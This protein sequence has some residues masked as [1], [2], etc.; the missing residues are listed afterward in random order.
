[1]K[2][3]IW[4]TVENVEDFREFF[5][6]ISLEIEGRISAKFSPNAR[7]MF[8]PS[9]AKFSPELRSGGLRGITLSAPKSRSQIAAFS[10]RRFSFASLPT[11]ILVQIARIEFATP[12]FASQR[13]SPSSL[14]QQSFQFAMGFAAKSDRHEFKSVPSNLRSPEMKH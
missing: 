2:N 1:M 11:N 10:I 8:R 4:C 3:F 13:V 12:I 9:L 5:A 14:G 6:A 7:R